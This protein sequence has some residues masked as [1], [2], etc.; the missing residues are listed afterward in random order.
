MRKAL[1]VAVYIYP[2]FWTYATTEQA[3]EWRVLSGPEK[4]QRV[5]LFV[6][7]PQSIPLL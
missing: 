6:L 1:L 5:V 4:E 7:S 2:L 3:Y